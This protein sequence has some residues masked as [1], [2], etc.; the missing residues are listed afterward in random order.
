MFA[1][2]NLKIS[3]T[4]VKKKNILHI[5]HV[6]TF[7]INIYTRFHMLHSND[8]LLTKIRPEAISYS[9]ILLVLHSTKKLS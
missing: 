2:H 5:K 4:A 3:V 8:S 9:C 1:R 6:D 7:V